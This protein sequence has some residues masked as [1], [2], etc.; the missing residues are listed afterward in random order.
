MAFLNKFKENMKD[1]D[2]N[3]FKQLSMDA[4]KFL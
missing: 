3:D 1:Y 4:L 2:K